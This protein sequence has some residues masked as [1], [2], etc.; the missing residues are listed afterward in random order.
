M[1]WSARWW[2]GGSCLAILALP[3]P[4]T[5]CRKISRYY[6]SAPASLCLLR[7]SPSW[8]N[9]RIALQASFNTCIFFIKFTRLLQSALF[10]ASGEPRLSF[11]IHRSQTL[12]SPCEQCSNHTKQQTTELREPA[13]INVCHS[14]QSFR[15]FSIL[16]GRETHSSLLWAQIDFSSRRA[17]KP[18]LTNT[19]I[20]TVQ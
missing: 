11:S 19:F 15:W 12:L 8:L 17:L 3:D 20:I 9:D 5:C 7:C 18:Q 16:H 4:F 10:V 2:S 13:R 6:R 1:I 14:F